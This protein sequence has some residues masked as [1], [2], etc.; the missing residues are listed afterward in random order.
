MNFVQLLEYNVARYFNSK[1]VR[2]VPDLFLFFEKALCKV[3][4]SG[5]Q[6]SFNIF[7]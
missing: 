5:Q 1:I 4:T 3:G 7:W 2:L 6:L